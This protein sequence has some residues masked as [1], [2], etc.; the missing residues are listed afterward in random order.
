MSV[1]SGNVLDENVFSS[2][3]G[4]EGI[5]FNLVEFETKYAGVYSNLLGRVLVADSLNAAIRIAKNQRHKFKIVTLDGQV[6]NAGGSMTGGSAASGAG[7]LSRANELLRLTEQIDEYSVDL[8]KA[9]REHAECIREKNAAEYELE[10]ARSELRA[11]E[12]QVIK[13]E[14]EE[15]HCLQ[16][17]ETAG[18]TISVFKRE[19]ESI[20]NRIS[21]NNSETESARSRISSTETELES[22]RDKIEEATRGQE[23]LSR[24]R[25]RVNLALSEI[26]AQGASLEAE[27]IALGKS[28]SELSALRD[29]M[30]S[31]RDR[32]LETIENL[33]GDNKRISK[34][35]LGYER[36]LTVIIDEIESLKHGLSL[37][38]ANKLEIEAKRSSLNKELQEKN[39]ELLNLERECSRLEQRKLASQMEEK[40][41]LDKL[42][43]TYELSRSAAMG[44]G[45]PIDSVAEAQRR[46]SSIKKQISELG[47]PNIGA[48]DEFER[49]NTRFIFM[50]S[51]RD[52]V[53]KAKDE[54]TGIIGELTVQMR[55]IFIREFE[56]INESFEKTFKELFGGGHASLVL[57][58]P[59]DVLEC[60]I[61]INVQPPGKSLKTLTLLSGGEK[62][63]VAIAIYFA[64]L[65]VRPP[66]FVIMDEIDAALDDANVLRFAEHLRRMS[67][68]TQ[69]IVITHQRGTMEEADILYGITMQ[70]LGVSSLL[71]I[72][73]DEA[74]KHISHK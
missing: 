18:E 65:T 40:Q 5:A 46:I 53:E 33:K 58:D 51:Q 30:Y 42:W 11:S 54:I 2:E 7:I 37:T 38:N 27:N 72:D 74:E 59:G 61:E 69:M 32:Q 43:D 66:P 26:R 50:T 41:I 47:N 34:E 12:E 16:L 6:I 36:A 23:L 35:I 25:D 20:N 13:L 48:I 8:K 70:E 73:L 24:E 31:S 21:L 17:L 64:I 15:S 62:A 22:L 44:A 57:E 67:V 29:E 10:T 19:L 9:E 56:S 63:F 28:V 60:G 45:M 14:I 4:F 39:H 55:E 1:I 3:E 52:D 49:I 71:K 68:I